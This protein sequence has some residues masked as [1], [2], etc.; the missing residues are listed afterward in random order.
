MERHR[1][2]S[3]EEVEVAVRES[4]HKQG[5]SF[6]RNGILMSLQCGIHACV[7]GDGLKM[8]I[9]WNRLPAFNVIMVSH[10]IFVTYKNLTASAPLVY[11][12]RNINNWTAVFLSCTD[13]LKGD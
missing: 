3:N 10:L 12:K 6:Y 9:Y 8:I 5:P 13:M 4:F 1:S 7:L 2:H 11:I